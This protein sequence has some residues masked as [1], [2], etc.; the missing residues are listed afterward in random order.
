MTPLQVGLGSGSAAAVIFAVFA[1][2][3]IFTAVTPVP[4]GEEFM[5]EHFGRFTRALSPG[6]PF[7]APLMDKIGVRI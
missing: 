5:P 6:L 1:I 3:T 7:I 2:I 4:Q